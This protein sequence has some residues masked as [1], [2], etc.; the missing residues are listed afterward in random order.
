M[1][2]LPKL[3]LQKL[4]AVL[5][6]PVAV[7]VVLAV[8]IVAALL[9]FG[10][11]G[12]AIAAG[13][14]VL[15]LAAGLFFGGVYL[16]KRRDKRAVD[17]TIAG[18]TDS[19]GAQD[20]TPQARE[21]VAKLRAK[22]E[23]EFKKVRADYVKNKPILMIVG[24][25]KSGKSVLLDRSGL[26]LES[27]NRQERDWEEG[28][29]NV[30]PWFFP[31]GL[32]LD[33]A[34]EMVAP[35]AGSARIDWGELVKLITTL[36]PRNPV[37]GVI[38]AVPVWRL[39]S[40]DENAR[41]VQANLFQREFQRLV[42]S[43][44]VR[45][46]V[47]VVVTMADL[48]D[49]YSEFALRQSAARP[50]DKYTMLGWP[51]YQLSDEFGGRDVMGESV[52]G[53]TARI[54]AQVLH[55]TC[56]PETASVE[57][58]EALEI[59]CFPK[60]IRSIGQRLAD[61]LKIVFKEKQSERV[62]N[63]PF[64]R[65]VFFGSS[66]QSIRR[67]EPRRK[68]PE[69]PRSEPFNIRDLLAIRLFG[70][71]GLVTT[72]P[73]AEAAARTRRLVGVGVPLVVAVVSAAVALIAFDLAGRV[74]KQKEGLQQLATRVT[75]AAS[76]T[77]AMQPAAGGW[78]AVEDS[79]PVVRQAVAAEL[80]D[81]FAE[82]R[83]F[84]VDD[85]PFWLGWYRGFADQREALASRATERAWTKLVAMPVL[86]RAA[87]EK[88]WRAGK[89]ASGSYRSLPL[90]R[91]GR[92][93]RPGDLNAELG[94]L[95]RAV[96]ASLR[97]V[98]G[99][100]SQTAP[101]RAVLK[102]SGATGSAKPAESASTSLRPLLVAMIGS[103]PDEL[104]T[105]LRFDS[106]WRAPA[107]A[108]DLAR[109]ADAL[110]ERFLGEKFVDA[111]RSLLLAADTHAAWRNGKVSFEYSPE[112]DGSG[113]GLTEEPDPADGMDE[114]IDDG[115]DDGIDDG[116][117]R[118]APV[119]PSTGQPARAGAFPSTRD[120]SASGTVTWSDVEADVWGVI[121]ELG[122][123]ETPP[124]ARWRKIAAFI[125][126]PDAADR[127]AAFLPS[128][129]PRAS[130]GAA[131][132][133][134]VKRIERLDD[135]YSAR[136]SGY[137]DAAREVIKRIDALQDATTY[138]PGELE[139]L[140]KLDLSRLVVR[141]ADRKPAE[142]GAE[143]EEADADAAEDESEEDALK[144]A[145]GELRVYLAPAIAEFNREVAG[146]LDRSVKGAVIGSLGTPGRVGSRDASGGINV[147]EPL[148]DFTN[149]D[150]LGLQAKYEKDRRGLDEWYKGLRQKPKK[151]EFIEVAFVSAGQ[152]ID[153]LARDAQGARRDW[154]VVDPNGYEPGTQRAQAL[155]DAILRDGVQA[156]E[157]VRVEVARQR[158]LLDGVG[159]KE[160]AKM[161]A[162]GELEDSIREVVQGASTGSES[163]RQNAANFVASLSRES[164]IG[165]RVEKGILAI[166][167]LSSADEQAYWMIFWRDLLVVASEV[168]DRRQESVDTLLTR[169]SILFPLAN[170]S[171]ALIARD[172][173]SLARDGTAARS[174]DAVA[175]PAKERAASALDQLWR[176]QPI[177]KRRAD[178]EKR[179][180]NR[181]LALARI[182][183]P[184]GAEGPMPGAKAVRVTIRATGD[185]EKLGTSGIGAISRGVI[186]ADSN[187]WGGGAQVRLRATGA[188]ESVGG[189]ERSREFSVR[190]NMPLEELTFEWRVDEDPALG[191]LALDF[192]TPD[193]I[194]G[195][196]RIKLD[197]RTLSG[198]PWSVLRLV[199]E[200][201]PIAADR[202]AALSSGSDGFAWGA[203]PAVE[204]RDKLYVAVGIKLEWI[205]EGESEKT[206]P[207]PVVD[208]LR[209]SKAD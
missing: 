67:G 203:L 144:R 139:T 154:R 10:V 56:N 63:A 75:A 82:A 110:R 123:A 153:Q 121:A 64:F 172:V 166:D 187:D 40:D 131:S 189:G 93:G 50:G 65:G 44:G 168:R 184:A 83:G 107:R 91:S 115:V 8:A 105:L 151:G 170:E 173:Q 98:T 192:G 109:E 52:N 190:S 162:H 16:A 47:S 90:E 204:G 150:G 201:Q 84:R 188:P 137:V 30:D 95:D 116:A 208:W 46:P 101:T 108:L 26:E 120:S 136:E 77:D 149:V 25:S 20:N 2:D 118:N 206:V 135:L 14:L 176:H 12:P 32:V 198:G 129:R 112:S 142:Q 48:V 167:S 72:S 78:I 89:S 202:G 130:L 191:A 27:D 132:I 31:E 36:R 125:D 79:K 18:M 111:T 37:S 57:A 99:A 22:W 196:E 179:T 53:V 197:A 205:L 34:G 104:E 96:G 180:A 126:A 28:T 38:L 141:P 138:V 51:Q 186:E 158:A 195:K 117:D 24:E 207:I 133:G 169:A 177:A 29:E 73:R 33:T 81:N 156:V 11:S 58:R 87:D 49:G 1:S 13:A 97:A 88:S 181:A 127:L 175:I 3:P 134:P 128:D 160:P 157:K 102:A 23:R 124:T 114:G 41:I 147:L 35:A 7:V 182:L 68:E 9:Y 178:A 62:A 55:D 21:R 42:H 39:L 103:P 171:D 163:R 165:K 193:E 106:G 74:A 92:A 94:E 60:N 164:Q 85:L 148:S 100:P 45:F 70:E 185:W 161:P 59:W 199:H 71:A 15:L 200:L 209:E 143:P 19:I 119:R 66:M 122:E 6:S 76:A 183:A 86:A 146:Y 69:R 4:L 145:E 174:L 194:P 113:P 140:V 155:V 152:R 159:S 17:A 5:L 61:Y 43:F 80:S 54:E